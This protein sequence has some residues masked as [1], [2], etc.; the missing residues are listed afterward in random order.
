MPLTT[1]LP[2]PAVVPIL[3]GQFQESQK[4]HAIDV[5]ISLSCCNSGL[6]RG[7]SSGNSVQTN[8]A[9]SHAAPD[10]SQ[11]QLPHLVH[12]NGNK[13]RQLPAPMCR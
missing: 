11:K 9:L 10:T 6:T 4:H 13:N 5:R 7:V 3:N 2:H 1:L 8:L 12:P